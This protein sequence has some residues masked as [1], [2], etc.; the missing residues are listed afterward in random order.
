MRMQKST[1]ICI[2]MYM[3]MRA[4]LLEVAARA[5]EGRHARGVH[6]DR[7]AVRINNSH[8]RSR[9]RNEGGKAQKEFRV[10]VGNTASGRQSGYPAPPC[11]ALCCAALRCPAPP[12]A[13]PPCAAP[14]C[15]V[16]RCPALPTCRGCVC[17]SSF[18]PCMSSKVTQS[19]VESPCRF[20][21]CTVAT[22][23]LPAQAPQRHRRGTAEARTA[24]SGYT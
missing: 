24:D 20:S 1:C 10:E 18:M 7:K 19:P 16:L 22:P 15:P 2:R 13:A 6:A 4:D 11:P 12:C 8:L 3:C 14:P 23:G 9:E 17:S 21:S 5:E